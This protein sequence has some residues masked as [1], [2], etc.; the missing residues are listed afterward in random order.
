MTKTA[1][2]TKAEPKA[3]GDAEAKDIL[4]S[5]KD[6][7]PK[8]KKA[9]DTVAEKK[10]DFGFIK[11]QVQSNMATIKT[12]ADDVSNAL[13]EKAPPQFKQEATDVKSR[14]DKNFDAALAA[15]Q[16]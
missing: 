16:S 14:I 5:V 1:S 10:A 9:T 11:S 3:V 4:S 12:G 6:L 15:L 13:Q 7:E 2:D 8:I